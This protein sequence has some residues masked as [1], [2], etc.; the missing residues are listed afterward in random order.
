VSDTNK[1]NKHKN[2][3]QKQKSREITKQNIRKKNKILRIKPDQIT[4]RR[5]E[6]TQQA[7]KE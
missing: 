3:P 5:K 6:R 2:I 4:V 7:R 1:E